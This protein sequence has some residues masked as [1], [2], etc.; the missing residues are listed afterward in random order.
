MSKHTIYTYEKQNLF[1]TKGFECLKTLI[2][3]QDDNTLIVCN[4]KLQLTALEAYFL[5]LALIK[6]PMLSIAKG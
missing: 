3:Y 5:D 6:Q 1:Q 2:T 4:S